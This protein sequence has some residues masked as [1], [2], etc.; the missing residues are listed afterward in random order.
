MQLYVN[1]DI[2]LWGPNAF[3]PPTQLFGG[4]GPHRP[5][6]VPTSM[7]IEDVREFTVVY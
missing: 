2:L 5:T 4:P 3:L 6:P 7:H 1:L